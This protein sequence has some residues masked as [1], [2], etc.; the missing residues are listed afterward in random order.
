MKTILDP[1]CGSKMFWF[2]KK[3]PRV[4]FGDI[5]EEAHQLCDGRTLSIDPDM[6]V[7]FTDMPFAN[8]S[9]KVVVFDPPHLTGAGPKGWQALKYGILP[10]DWKE[11]ISLGFKECFRVLDDYG[12]LIFKWNEERIKI[13][14]IL[15]L[16]PYR[17]LFGHT[18]SQ[19]GKTHWF[20]FMKPET[21]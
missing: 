18:T 19:N 17:P 13:K 7:D 21:L 14:E 9:F 6:K 8:K 1:C 12:V 15:P 3:D 10:C 5:R 4:L 20:T 2:D 11:Y 16:T